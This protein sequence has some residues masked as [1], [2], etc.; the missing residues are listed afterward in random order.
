MQVQVHYQGMDS[1][2]WIDQFITRKLSK[3]ERYLTP[4]SVIHVHLKLD[5]RNYTTTLEVNCNHHRN[6]AFNSVGENL[7]ESFSQA[8]DKAARVLNEEKRKFKDRI[9]GRFFSLKKDHAA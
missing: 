2:E 6:Y 4:A 7:Y 3:L 5:H 8:I 9:N 1:S